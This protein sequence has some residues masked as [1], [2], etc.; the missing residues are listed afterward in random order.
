MKPLFQPIAIALCTLPSLVSCTSSTDDVEE[1]D[2]GTVISLTA[3][4]DPENHCAVLLNMQVHEGV[5]LQVEHTLSDGSTARQT[6][7][8]SSQDGIAYTGRV[9][10]LYADTEYTLSISTADERTPET[11]VTDTDVAVTTLPLPADLPPV[12]LKQIDTT[13][14]KD[15]LT[16][17][18]IN[19]FDPTIQL[20]WGYLVAVDQTGN[21]VWY[22]SMG[23][24]G[25]AF[26]ITDDGKLLTSLAAGAAVEVEP[27]SGTLR[28]WDAADSLLDTV[29]HEVLAIEEDGL[30][31]LSSE[32]RSIDGFPDGQTYNIIGDVLAEVNWDGSI[33]WEARLLDFINPSEQFSED[34]HSTF[35]E[36]PPYDE[37]DAPK[38][39]SHGNAMTWDPVRLEWTAS[40]RNLDLIAGFSKDPTELRWTFGPDGDFALTEGSRWFSRQH[41]PTWTSDGTLLVYDNGLQRADAEPE[42]PP[43]T[44]VVEYALDFN[45]LT[46]TEIWSFSGHTPYLA[47]IVGTVERLDENHHLI[48]DGAI[49]GGNNIHEEEN[50][51]HF[52]AR[53]LELV[54]LESPETVFELIVGAPEDLTQSGA[55][56]YRAERVA[57]DTLLGVS[58][59]P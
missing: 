49:Y 40:F 37:I 45:T 57:W 27:I 53:I 11:A 20:D 35:W 17:F 47:P 8:W 46:A 42:E 50:I 15:G 56:V 9:V 25:F 18:P 58:F 7:E 39:W 32:N 38:D 36:M 6:P 44:R 43:F 51:A 28:V 48:T 13:R 23:V 26:N 1:L 14:A 22:Q 3:T 41:A 54:G 12:S 5:P 52:S 16:V 29:H 4:V 33:R 10:G 19:L 30:A 2:P 34:M 59:H 31:L 55:A 24:L 21:I